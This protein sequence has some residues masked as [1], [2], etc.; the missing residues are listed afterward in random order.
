MTP[1]PC[2]PFLPALGLSRRALLTAGLS[3]ACN[4]PFASVRRD[5][6]PLTLA[7][8]APEDVDPRGW[9]ISE[10]LDGAR[11]W[12]DGSRLRFRSGLPI[13]APA[14]FTAALPAYALDG[15]L[16]LGRGRFE[17]LSGVVRRLQ[18]V[19]A[20]WRQVRLM[21]FELPGAAGS[22]AQRAEQIRQRAADQAPGTPWSAVGQFELPN[23]QA[24]RARLREVVDAGGEGL[25]LHRADAPF[26]SGRSGS[27]L[28]L[29]P[30]QDAE[31]VVI[32]HVGGQGR[33]T[34]RLGA[35]KV[36]TSDGREFHLGTGL[37]DEQ[38]D[39]PPPVGTVVTYTYQGTTA[40]GIPRFAS[41]LRVRTV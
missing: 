32:G 25:M 28:K 21:V 1:H 14:W 26:E 12:W 5:P 6:V 16:W 38:R 30:L 23:R 29:K 39:R 27:L 8:E 2:P 31:A 41:F 19:D 37:S 9:L 35:L 34:G 24:L 11:A 3:C 17:Q 15:E 33:H 22:F 36:R 18:P 4:G 40:Q 10:K 13:M 7:G 20:E